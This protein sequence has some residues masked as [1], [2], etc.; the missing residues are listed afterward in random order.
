MTF[1][2]PTLGV[3]NLACHQ[4]PVSPMDC[5]PSADYFSSMGYTSVGS[6]SSPVSQTNQGSSHGSSHSLPNFPGAV[7]YPDSMPLPHSGGFA[8]PS[9]H[10][11]SMSALLPMPYL[12]QP[13]T[14]LHQLPTQT[15]RH[16]TMP[17]ARRTLTD[18]DRRRMCLYHQENPHV[19][20]TE[21]GAMFG[22]ERR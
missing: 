13:F 20:Q 6:T 4:P 11:H 3:P 10:H 14:G 9:P 15:M 8:T 18:D 16:P 5:S 7:D 12:Y 17:T 22:V 21:I 1:H 19:K 2:E